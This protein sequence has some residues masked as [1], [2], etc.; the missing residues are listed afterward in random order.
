MSGR[1]GIWPVRQIPVEVRYC[2]YCN[3]PILRE[4]MTPSKYKK[5]VFCKHLCRVAYNEELKSA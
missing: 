3:G 5:K 1:L 2:K 4:N